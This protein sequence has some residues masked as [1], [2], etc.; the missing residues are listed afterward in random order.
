MLRFMG[1]QSPHGRSL[2]SCLYFHSAFRKSNEPTGL[3]T[4]TQYLF[5]LCEEE[6]LRRSLDIKWSGLDAEKKYK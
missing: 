6:M 5:S 2:D 4:G 3:V 1:L